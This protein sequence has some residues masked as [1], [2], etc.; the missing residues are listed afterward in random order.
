[1]APGEPELQ[2]LTESFKSRASHH[3]LSLLLISLS[4]P[5]SPGDNLIDLL[6]GH[7]PGGSGVQSEAVLVPG[8]NI[9]GGDSQDTVSINGE[10]VVKI[11]RSSRSGGNVLDVELTENVVVLGQGSLTFN[12]DN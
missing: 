7:S 10:Y 9:G 5:I 3:S 11:L 6:S 12:R 8:L 4:H 1:M 2:F